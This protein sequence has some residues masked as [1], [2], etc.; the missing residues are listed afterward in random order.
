MSFLQIIYDSS[1]KNDNLTLTTTEVV[2][3][4]CLVNLNDNLEDEIKEEIKNNSKDDLKEELKEEESKEEDLKEEDLKEEDLKEE[5]S[6]KLKLRNGLRS[7]TKN[8]H[9]KNDTI[10]SNSIFDHLIKEAKNTASSDFHL[11]NSF[12]EKQTLNGF[13]KDHEQQL[14][15]FDQC[16]EPNRK[17]NRRKNQLELLNVYEDQEFNTINLNKNDNMKVSSLHRNKNG[18]KS[19]FKNKQTDFNLK[20]LKNFKNYQNGLIRSHTSKLKSVQRIFIDDNLFKYNDG[21]VNID[22]L[23]LDQ[24][25]AT[26]K[27]ILKRRNKKFIFEDIEDQSRLDYDEFTNQHF[28]S[29][30]SRLESVKKLN[31]IEQPNQL[32]NEISSCSNSSSSNNQFATNLITNSTNDS[33]T[34]NLSNLYQELINNC[35]FRS[36]NESPV[37]DLFTFQDKN[38]S[39]LEEDDCQTS[40]ITLIQLEQLSIWTR[41]PSQLEW[42]PN[43]F[44][45][46]DNQKIFRCFKIENDNYVCILFLVW[47]FSLISLKYCYIDKQT[48]QARLIHCETFELSNTDL[49]LIQLCF[50]NPNFIALSI[51]RIDEDIIDVLIYDEINFEIEFNKSKRIIYM[52]NNVNNKFSSP[53]NCF[54]VSDELN[55]TFLAIFNQKLF[56]WYVCVFLE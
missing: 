26:S 44:K 50:I 37:F 8:D 21:L 38:S 39:N 13:S 15:I 49:N 18:L 22:D 24:L 42:R 14:Y 34:S 47:S 25:N 23:N 55:N 6:I 17:L 36:T 1:T 10:K 5:D 7:H 52:L 2:D 28:N 46:E 29:H 20:E 12:F 43:I 27:F 40:I 33:S 16:E 11:D 9:L 19:K 54:L 48:K 51:P 53:N 35:L 45:L 30:Q 31:S 3:E 4:N 32:A 56:M 41:L